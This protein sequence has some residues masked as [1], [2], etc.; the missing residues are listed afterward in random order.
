MT[1][2]NHTPYDIPKTYKPYSLT[3]PAYM[4]TI[5]N[6]EKAIALNNF[7][8]YQYVNDCLG[9]FIKRIHASSLKDNTIIVAVGDHSIL[10][11]FKTPDSQLHQKFSI[12]FILFVPEAYKPKYEVDQS[13]F[14][15]HKDVFPT[16]FNISLSNAEYIKSGNNLMAPPTDSTYFFGVYRYRTGFSKDGC[17]LVDDKLYFNWR[18][19][20]YTSL[21]PSPESDK[22]KYLQL[23]T[24]AYSATMS[25]FI[26]SELKKVE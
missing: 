17:V 2:T 23:K 18:D 10:T 5:L 22:T 9:K 6:A 13:R 12:P 21:I 15:S 26:K 7:L 1:T 14:G 19:S 8:S 3:M 24:R 16:V 25:A 20:S 11:L 4:D